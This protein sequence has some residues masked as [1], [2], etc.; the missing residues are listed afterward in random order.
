M[1]PSTRLATIAC[2]CAGVIALFFAPAAAGA[3]RLGSAPILP[4]GAHIAGA[5]ASD[6]PVHVTVTLQPRDGAA[7]EAFATAVS[8]PGSPQYRDYVTP[9]QF[10]QRFGAAPDAVAAVEA[11]LRAH[12]LTPGQPSPNALSIPV[13]ATAGTVSR[14]FAVSFAHVTLQNGTTA[15]VNQQPPALDPAIAPDVQ[16]VLGLDTVSKAKPLL[17]HPDTATPAARPH[18]VTGGP[19]P[20]CSAE[21]Q[22]SQGGFTDDQIASAYGL[23][24]LYQAGDFGAGQTV[25][26]IELEPYDLTD[27]QHYAS[28]YSLNGQPLNPQIANVP[29]DGGAGSGSGSGEA[30]LD[31]ENVIGLAPQANV[32]VYEG[33]NSGSGPYDTFSRI[34]TDHASQVVTASWG[35][36]E[37]INGSGQAAAENTLF[38]EAATEGI[39]IFSASGDDG[40][41]DCFPENPTAQVDDPASQPFVTGVGGTQVNALGPR[42]AETVWNDGVR[43]GASGGGISTFWKMPSY[44]VEAPAS[45]H[46]V[47]GGSSGSPCGATSGV[48]REVPDVS[49]DAS[50]ATGYVIYWNGTGAAGLGQ[51]QGWQVVG[52]TSGAAP[53]WAALIALAN[54]SSA[55]NGTRVGFANPALYN[56]AAS[57]YAANF[58]DTTSGNNDMT[59]S[60]LGQ[61]AAG[62]GYDM[63]T[64]LG[65][66]NGSALTGPL[67][68]DA[69][70]LR[71]PGPQRSTL[72]TPVSLQIKGSDTRGASVHFSATGLPVGLSIHSSSGKITGRPRRLGTSTVT[73][74]A[75][76][77][78][79][80][81]AHV[82]FAWTIQTK[83]K[84]S[85]VSLSSV[86]AARPRLSFMV[87]AGRDAPKLKTVSV[88]LPRGLHFTR[89]RA[90]VRVT[91][92]GNHR[93]RYR[94]SLQHGTLVLKF[95]SP[96]QQLHVTIT[97]PRLRAGGSLVSDLARHRGTRVGLTVRAT[98][99][100][101]L[102]TRLTASFKPRS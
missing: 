20:A 68:A 87:T 40:A 88:T 62:P 85:R 8:T 46:V 66:P 45:L 90:T 17:V 97:Y 56:A 81:T 77:V 4:L 22:Q 64:G 39:S 91:G 12:G 32:A 89:A 58:N 16:A 96:V 69:I 80:A 52:G 73:V 26:V 3:T 34:I 41:E 47:N 92:R 67:C 55:C 102:T 1:P 11:S 83:P 54:A 50:P 19:E 60:N 59:G 38:Q 49:A 93:V 27:I 63:A 24:G 6:T 75:D 33:P 14:A 35:Q 5:V 36:C 99:A 76:N 57:N 42:P 28:C 9:A 78:V 25:A 48:C 61:F 65:S 86:G 30:A 79:G 18:V 43:V 51:P 98:D 72:N 2:A 15:I 37:F 82:T 21:G 53:A 84:L 100:L 29:V 95:A 44:Q 94:V 101:K 70:S 23:S 7:L 10:A 74:S 13:T 71:N 31:I